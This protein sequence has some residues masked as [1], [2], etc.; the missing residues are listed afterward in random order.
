MGF[1]KE[2]SQDELCGRRNVFSLK[3]SKAGREVLSFSEFKE[4]VGLRL[5]RL[6]DALGT[7]LYTNK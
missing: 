3:K 2:A 6:F 1:L 4:G 7:M 5:E